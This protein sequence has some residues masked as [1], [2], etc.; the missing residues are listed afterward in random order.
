[1]ETKK[2]VIKNFTELNVWKKGHLVVLSI[3]QLTRRFPKSEL[4]GLSS[5]LQRAAV[6]ITSNI[7]EGFGRKGGKEKAQFYAISL[8]SV[9]ELQNQIYIAKDLGYITEEQGTDI[10]S[11]SEEISR[12]ISGLINYLKS[13]KPNT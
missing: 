9:A 3:Y 12:M 4:Y 7:A 5:Q 2:E 6:S 1:M 11:R 10:L 8:G 13:P